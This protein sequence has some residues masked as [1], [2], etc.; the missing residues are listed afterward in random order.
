MKTETEKPKKRKIIL[1]LRGTEEE[2]QKLL[3]QAQL[4]GLSVNQY[5]RFK[6]GLE[7]EFHD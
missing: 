7:V 2:K 6:L 3:M 4:L 1:T 5:V